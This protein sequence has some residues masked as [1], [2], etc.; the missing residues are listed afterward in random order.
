M[1]RR[2]VSLPWKLLSVVG[3]LSVTAA[4]AP[5]KIVTSILG[6]RQQL[7]PRRSRTMPKEFYDV[8]DVAAM[9]SMIQAAMYDKSQQLHLEHS[10][11]S[12]LDKQVEELQES[13]ENVNYLFVQVGK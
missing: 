7:S 12:Q 10:K 9:L 11:V 4:V 5:F 8:Q 2:A 1:L 6:Q 13:L 3:V